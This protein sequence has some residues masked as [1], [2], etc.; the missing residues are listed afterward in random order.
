MKASSRTRLPSD[1]TMVG[2]VP[3]VPLVWMVVRTREP[4]RRGRSR[5]SGYWRSA[6]LVSRLLPRF[7]TCRAT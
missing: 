6:C 4:K 5:R 3:E 2:D 1:W 7:S